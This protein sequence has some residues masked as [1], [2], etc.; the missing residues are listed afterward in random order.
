VYRDRARWAE[1]ARWPWDGIQCRAKP[2]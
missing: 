2:G 1:H